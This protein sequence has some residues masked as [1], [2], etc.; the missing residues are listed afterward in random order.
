MSPH[1]MQ[2]AKDRSGRARRFLEDRLF[3]PDGEWSGRGDFDD[4]Q[5]WAALVRLEM[6]LGEKLTIR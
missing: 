4:I 5:C 3:D 2:A 6:D 1:E